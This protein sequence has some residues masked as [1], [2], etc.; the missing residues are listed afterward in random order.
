MTDSELLSKY[1]VT[2][3]RYTSYPPANYFTPS[4]QAA[5][6]EAVLRESDEASPRHLSFY[7]H[8]PFCR[9]L[10]HYCGCNAF[11]LMKPDKVD[12]YIAALHKE[13]DR[14]AGCVS[15]QRRIAQI[16]Y[17]GGTPTVLP[18]SVLK[19]LNAHLLASFPLIEQPE[20]AIECH[21]GYLSEN[22]WLSL[23]EAGFNR[24][25]LGIQDFDVKVLKAV[26]R[27]PSLLPL[28]L[29]FRILRERKAGINL[30]F[31]YGL[32]L[33]TKESF[34]QT[35]AQAIEL[36]P[37]RLVTFS[38]AHV[39]WVNKRQLIL[40]QKGLPAGEEK[41][42]MYTFAKDILQQAGYKAIGLDHFVKETDEL[43]AALL[44]RRLHRN[45]QGYCTRRTTGQV[46]AFG[47][48]AISQLAGA[49]AQNSKDREDYM[50]RIENG[51]WAT[52]KGYRLDKEEQICREVIETL[53]CNYCLDWEELSEQLGLPV[54]RIK[55]ATAYKPALF[56]TFADDGIITHDEKHIRITTQ[57]TLFVRNVAAALDKLMLHTGKTFSKPV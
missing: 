29:I 25:S 11:A 5:D 43:Y 19:D 57:G 42:R 12:R 21:P 3:P 39:P 13:I 40:E 41:S 20:I 50:S 51:Q 52:V 36:Q 56:R 22:D 17:G 7:I 28:D 24:F 44:N 9:H 23:A 2:V 14:M 33:Q 18:A 15:P 4:F 30:D 38:Y 1:N 54:E 55:E 16:H 34:A 48:T 32:P 8:I 27:R 47:V 53:M 31:L 26:N 49:Y 45:F 35:I 10:C 6:Y 37:D 46:Y